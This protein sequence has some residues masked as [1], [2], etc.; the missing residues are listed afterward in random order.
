LEYNLT[1]RHLFFKI[2]QKD[3]MLPEWQTPWKETSK[4]LHVR[5]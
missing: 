3:K 2:G 4:N 1:L 5:A